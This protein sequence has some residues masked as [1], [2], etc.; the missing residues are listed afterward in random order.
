MKEN[1][2]AIC[3]QKELVVANW[4]FVAEILK[5]NVETEPAQ[6]HVKNGMFNIKK[7]NMAS[8]P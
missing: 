6:S 1:Y 5:K 7:E 4:H 3:C 8:G 2:L